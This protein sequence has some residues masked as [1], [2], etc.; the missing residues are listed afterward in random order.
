MV[1]LCTYN[2]CM[3]PNISLVCKK[4]PYFPPVQTV[5]G[6]L[7]PKNNKRKIK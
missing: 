4:C 1:Q 5:L 3:K 6:Q 2:K 7:P